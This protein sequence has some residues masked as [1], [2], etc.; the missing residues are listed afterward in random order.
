MA[1]PVTPEEAQHRVR[2]LYGNGLR[3]EVWQAFVDRFRVRIGEVYGS[4]EGTSNLVNIDGHVGACGF[5][6][7]SPLTKK[8]HPVRLIKVDDVTGEVVRKPSGLCVACNPGETG[9]MVSTIRTNNPLLQFEGYLNKSETDKKIIR[10]VFC[11]G[12]SC[13]VSGLD[14][15]PP[16]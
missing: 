15:S 13:F 16:S 3:A 11:K 1:Q 14:S 2:L 4:T 10:D 9:A 8:M 5:L 6:P 12:D 7:I